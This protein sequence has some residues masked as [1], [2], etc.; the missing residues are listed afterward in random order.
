[1]QRYK[2]HIHRLYQQIG[3]L[4][5]ELDWLKNPRGYRLISFGSRSSQHIKRGD[6]AQDKKYG[7]LEFGK[8]A[9]V[10]ESVTGYRG[11]ATHPRL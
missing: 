7:T 3:R 4:K 8:P 1:M 6:Y 10:S 11:A 5:V 9:A 2:E